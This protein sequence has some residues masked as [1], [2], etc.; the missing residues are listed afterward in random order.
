MN[1]H[2]A[3]ACIERLAVKNFRAMANIDIRELTPLTVLLTPNGSGRSTVF[4][5]FAFLSE[6]FR[7]GLRQ[8]W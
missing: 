3:P 7:S 4:G 2:A 6:C 1:T 5:I 8:A